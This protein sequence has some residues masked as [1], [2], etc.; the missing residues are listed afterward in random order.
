[1]ARVLPAWLP[2][3]AEEA[4]QLVLAVPAPVAVPEQAERNRIPS[5]SIP[6]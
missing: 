6:L 1:M 2:E 3:R 4:L 5:R